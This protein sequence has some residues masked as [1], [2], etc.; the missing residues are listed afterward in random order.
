[1]SQILV[2]SETHHGNRGQHHCVFG[3][4]LAPAHVVSAGGIYVHPFVPDSPWYGFCHAPDENR[5]AADAILQVKVWLTEISRLPWY[6][7]DPLKRLSLIAIL[8]QT[9]MNRLDGT[10]GYH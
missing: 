9:A 3:A 2:A 6:F 4:H 10:P 1:L 7:A 8:T 5:A